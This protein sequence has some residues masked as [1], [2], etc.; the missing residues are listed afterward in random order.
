MKKFYFENKDIK[1]EHKYDFPMS[2]ELCFL[3]T[4]LNAELYYFLS[5]D[6]KIHIDDSIYI[7][8]K[9]D[10]FLIRPNEPHYFEVDP[11][12][13]YERIVINFDPETFA[14]FDGKD[15]IKSCFY[16]RKSGQKNQ[17]CVSCFK[18]KAYSKFFMDMVTPSK[19]NEVNIYSNLFMILSEIADIFNSDIVLEVPFTDSLDSQIIRYVNDNLE[20][21]LNLNMLCERFYISRS[22]LN[23]IFNRN[24]GISTWDYILNKRLNKAKALLVAGYPSTRVAELCGFSNYSTFYRAYIKLFG[25]SPSYRST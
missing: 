19:S 12:F 17:Y 5:G 20:K 11:N 3:H 2:R 1:V 22:K 10:V 14:K 25:V 13:P 23:Q 15:Y 16:N 7:A 8:S 21:P 6:I 9:G 24:T 18:D 4:H